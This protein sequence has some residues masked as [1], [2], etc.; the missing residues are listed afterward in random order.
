MLLAV[1]GVGWALWQRSLDP[2]GAPVG[3]PGV[4][5]ADARSV[6]LAA[7]RGPGAATDAP[8]VTPRPS[9]TAPSAPEWPRHAAFAVDSPALLE[10][11][12]LALV[13]A[14]PSTGRLALA[15][16]ARTGPGTGQVEA[17]SA[18]AVGFAL[19]LP[20]LEVVGWASRDAA[21]G[22]LGAVPLSQWATLEAFTLIDAA[23]EPVSRATWTRASS[24]ASVGEALTPLP[25]DAEGRLLLPRHARF[26]LRAESTRGGATVALPCIERTLT[27]KALRR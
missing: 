22:D 5:G 2:A 6:A 3:T 25:C 18:T 4:G 11:P 26:E 24:L 17:G 12:G 16:W 21:S 23:G 10:H 20:E 19:R 1:G 15:P 13:I 7:E 27:L 8:E 14:E 9:P